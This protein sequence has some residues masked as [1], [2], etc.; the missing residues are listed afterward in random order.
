MKT[1]LHLFSFI[2][3]TCT[4]FNIASAAPDEKI[5]L[6]TVVPQ[7]TSTEIYRDWTPLL[8]QLEKTTGLRFELKVYDDY[9]RFEADFANG[10]PD[11]VFLNPYHMIVAQKKQRYRPLIRDS[12]TLSGILVTRQDSALKTPADLDGKSIAFPSPNALGAS[13][14]LRALLAEKYHVKIKPVYANGHQNVYRQ[15]ILGDVAAG[16]GIKKTLN[17]EAEGVKSQLKVIFNTPEIASH[18]L[19]AHPRVSKA[20]SN[21]IVA[22]LLAMANDS[23]SKKLLAAAQLP[24]PVEADFKRDYAGLSKLNLDRYAVFEK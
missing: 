7:F 19:A 22:A 17:K 13:L 2:F 21:K 15:V 3:L 8:A 1:L 23:E 18:P 24:Q 9:P 4:Q 14:F 16:G 11:L 5:Y 20:V 6:V 10:I 12:A